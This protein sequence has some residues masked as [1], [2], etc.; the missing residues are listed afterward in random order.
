MTF[1]GVLIS[2]RRGAVK[3]HPIKISAI[4]VTT[5][6]SITVCTARETCSSFFCPR[7]IPI[8]T[9]AP[10]DIPTKILI[11]RFIIGVLL[12]TAARASLPAKCPT[13]ATSA[14]LKNCCKTLLAARGSAK[15]NIFFNKGPLSMST[16]EFSVLVFTMSTF[17][18]L[19]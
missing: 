12:P 7:N 15:S 3:N 16:P 6:S 4:P 10:T 13:T 8:T 2:S 11:R 17:Y 1:S 14:E 5:E 18:R 9:F 19:F